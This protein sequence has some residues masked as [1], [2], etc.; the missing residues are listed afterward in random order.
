MQR[1]AS[2]FLEKADSTPTQIITSETHLSAM[3][4]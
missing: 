4:S 1:R 3:F 2:L